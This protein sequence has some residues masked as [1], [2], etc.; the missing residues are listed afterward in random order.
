MSENKYQTLREQLTYAPK[1]GHAKIS[2]QDKT[3][4]EAYCKRYMAFLNAAKT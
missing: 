2:D 4:M 3:K 1:N